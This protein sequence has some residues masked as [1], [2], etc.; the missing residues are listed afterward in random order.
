MT[1]PSAKSYYFAAVL[2]GLAVGV[3]TRDM[4]IGILLAVVLM[5]LVSGLRKKSR[6]Q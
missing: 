5:V 6:D 1:K 3:A 4:P 2:I